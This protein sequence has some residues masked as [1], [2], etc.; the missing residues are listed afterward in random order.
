[1]HRRPADTFRLD[2]KDR[3][4]VVH[5]FLKDLKSGLSGLLFH[6]GKRTVD[7]FLSYTFFTVQ[8]NVV[9]QLSDNDIL[10]ERIR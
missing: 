8:H 1:M 3:H 9:D 4:D 6:D 2:F 5:G 7:D 10:I